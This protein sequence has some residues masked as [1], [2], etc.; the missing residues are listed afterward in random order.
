[1]QQG[2]FEKRERNGVVYYAVSFLEA[3]GLVNAAFTTR[4]GGASVGEAATMNMSFARKDKPDSIRENYRRICAAA[5]FTPDG[6]AI[7]RQLHGEYVHKVMDAEIGRGIFDDFENVEADGLMS[8]RR[9]VALVKHTADCVPVYILDTKTPAIALAHAGWRGTL[10]GIAGVALRR[11]GEVY[12]TKPADCMAAI[13]PSI[14]PCCFE[15]GQDVAQAFTSRFPGFG[16]VDTAGYRPHVDL[17]RC[18]ALQ[19]LGAG[20]PNENIAISGLCTACDTAMFYSH[21]KEKGKTGAMAA[22][23]EL[24]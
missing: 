13:G 17:W 15:V 20:V 21:R 3:T 12:G 16:I 18:N 8:R 5:G 24:I 6:L 9:G 4:L 10:E 19:L 22:L 1:M 2:G 23:M 7:S 14:G 11:M